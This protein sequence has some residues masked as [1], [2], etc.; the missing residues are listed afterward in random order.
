[1]KAT[2]EQLRRAERNGFIHRS[3]RDTADRD[4]IAAR[5]C[6]RHGLT[7]QFLW[8]GLQAVEKHLK[9]I[10]LFH[11]VDTRRLNHDLVTALGMVKEI[12]G[13]GFWISE[14]DEEFL[15]YLHEQGPNR[16]FVF[17]RFTEG[18][19]LLAL[20]SLVWKVRR[21]CSDFFFPNRSPKRT[22][23]DRLRL[24]YVQSKECLKNPLVFRLDNQGFLEEVV[25]TDRHPQLYSALAWKNLNFG[26]R[27]KRTVRLRL[28]KRWSQPD[29]FMYPDLRAW[30]DGHVHVPRDVRELMNQKSRGQGRAGG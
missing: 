27:Q 25:D 8:S 17:P 13:L 4:Y 5:L 22:E 21:F 18:K 3:F 20:D 1:M 16:Y 2:P 10:L 14:K 28:S 24:E 19:D 6:C 23:Y 7:E 9:A 29:N 11:D 12:E 26:R 30:L 15:R